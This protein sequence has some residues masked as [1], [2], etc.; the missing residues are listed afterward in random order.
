MEYHL[1]KLGYVWVHTSLDVVFIV[2]GVGVLLYIGWRVV[3]L[4]GQH[5][6]YVSGQPEHGHK[7]VLVLGLLGRHQ[8]THSACVGERGELLI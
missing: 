3:V 2:G 8:V 6:V 5:E 1:T 7:D 4:V